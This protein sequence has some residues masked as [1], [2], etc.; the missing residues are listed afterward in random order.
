MLKIFGE[1]YYLDL[2]KIE[3]FTNI[4]NESGQT[5]NHISVVKYDMVKILIDV[6]LSDGE[7]ID[8]SLGQKS[9]QIGIPFKLAFNTL[10]NIKILNKY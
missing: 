6:I 3:E 5:E 7:E 1:H 2:D 10:L 8:E 4:K 9:S